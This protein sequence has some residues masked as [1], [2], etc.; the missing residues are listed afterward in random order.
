MLERHALRMK[1]D[2]REQANLF[3]MGST[4]GRDRGAGARQDREAEAGLRSDRRYVH[5]Q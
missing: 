4:P 1:P 2:F 3:G 5:A